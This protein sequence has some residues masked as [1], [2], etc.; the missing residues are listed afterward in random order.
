[1]TNEEHERFT[2]VMCEKYQDHLDWYPSREEALKSI[3]SGVV[4]DTSL[5]LD[6]SVPLEQWEKAM[7]EA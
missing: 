2:K 6:G 3:I 4:A 7:A 5:I 1:M